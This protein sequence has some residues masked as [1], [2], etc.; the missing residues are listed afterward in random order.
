[1]GRATPDGR[2]KVTQLR[3]SRAGRWL[4]GFVAAWAIVATATHQAPAAAS[5]DAPRT[6]AAIDLLPPLAPTGSPSHPAA[7]ADAGFELVLSWPGDGDLAGL[8]TRAG[9]DEQSANIAARM[10]H[11]EFGGEVPAGSDIKLVLGLERFGQKTLRRLA[12]LTDHGEVALVSGTDGILVSVNHATLA[13]RD[14]ALDGDAY[15][16][17]RRAGLDSDISAEADRLLP[18]AAT[19]GTLRLVTGAR[20]DR[21][22]GE[23]RPKLLYVEWSRGGARRSW[24]RLADTQDGWHE[25]GQRAKAGLTRP[26]TGRLTSAFGTRRHPILGFARLHR[27]VDFSAPWGAPVRAAADGVVTSAEWRGGYGRQ[28]RIAHPHS[29][30][31]TYAHLSAMTVAPGRRVS[32]GELIGYAGASGLATG[33]HLHFEVYRGGQVVD[34]LVVDMAETGTNVHVAALVERLRR[35]PAT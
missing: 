29:V 15:W 16:S 18:N 20:P 22:S 1:M 28:V 6:I 27:G 14:A 31:T 32:R 25:I 34:P 8:L 26:V 17:L 24:V 10:I 9:T 3:A 23:G 13:R 33:P 7:P 12:I 19:G 30:V 21:F 2:P 11:G 35:A 5:A 4:A